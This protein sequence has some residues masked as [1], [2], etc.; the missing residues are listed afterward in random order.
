VRFDELTNSTNLSTSSEVSFAGLPAFWCFGVAFLVVHVYW[1]A[2]SVTSR[3]QAISAY[4]SP[5]FRRRSI[6]RRVSRFSR[7]RLGVQGG[8]DI[9]ECVVV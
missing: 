6:S 3:N 9:I 1:T 2:R 5:R 7:L 4:V 8:V